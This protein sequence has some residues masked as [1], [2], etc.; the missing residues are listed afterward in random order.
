MAEGV[1]G[2]GGASLLVDARQ[3][4][5][6][7][8]GSAILGDPPEE[9]EAELGGADLG[10]GTSRRS[11]RVCWGHSLQPWQEGCGGGGAGAGRGQAAGP[12]SG[13][14]VRSKKLNKSRSQSE[15]G[16]EVPLRRQGRP[17]MPSNGGFVK[18]R[19]TGGGGSR[20]D[21]LAAF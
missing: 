7:Q 4:L 20:G 2:R 3:L 12:S 15:R 9:P 17:W 11:C 21:K 6:E 10:D 1:G 19:Q 16:W 13:K 18:R 14:T 8:Q 5:R